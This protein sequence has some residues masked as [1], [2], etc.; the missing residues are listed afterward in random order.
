ME[1]L[2]PNVSSEWSDSE[3]IAEYLSGDTPPRYPEEM[4]LSALPE[5][6]ARLVDLGTGDGR[7]ISLV[8]SRYPEA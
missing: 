2:T 6:V 1:E 7:L 5:H 4:L 3:H 8:R